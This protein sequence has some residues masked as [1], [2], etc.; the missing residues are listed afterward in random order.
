VI[1]AASRRIGAIG[2]QRMATELKHTIDVQF[3]LAVS[4]QSLQARF[5]KIAG[6][7]ARMINDL[8]IGNAEKAVADQLTR[9][10][11]VTAAQEAG[12]SGY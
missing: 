3:G 8:T 9:Q 5:A 7:L 4:E 11:V 1:S 2:G 10:G 6:P 12:A